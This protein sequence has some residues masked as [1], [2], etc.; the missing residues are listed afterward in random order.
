MN[1]LAPIHFNFQFTFNITFTSRA[2]IMSGEVYLF[3]THSFV[4][5][6]W[7]LIC[8]FVFQL[9]WHIWSWL[10]NAAVI[11]SV[12]EAN[13]LPQ[14]SLELPTKID[15]KTLTQICEKGNQ[16]RSWRRRRQA[17]I[18]AFIQHCHLPNGPPIENFRD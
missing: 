7:K 3:S 17:Q 2:K 1:H 10:V 9:W 15:F 18:L 16:S 11:V 14:T 12:S 6:M 4:I 5:H 8:E 13:N